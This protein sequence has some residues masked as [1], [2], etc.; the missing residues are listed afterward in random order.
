MYQAYNF[1]LVG[2]VH[3]SG[4]EECQLNLI[5]MTRGTIYIDLSYLWD[6]IALDGDFATSKDKISN[7]CVR[8]PSL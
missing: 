1:N 6:F 8:F 4:R 5:E 7:N 2:P 3:K